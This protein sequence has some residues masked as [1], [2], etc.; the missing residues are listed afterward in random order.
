MNQL[1]PAGRD[2]RLGLVVPHAGVRG[3]F[4]IVLRV[5]V[6]GSDVGGRHCSRGL[7]QLLLANV[8]GLAGF[9]V[10]LVSLGKSRC[11]GSKD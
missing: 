2:R 7:G 11:S 8:A 4:R 10:R 6:A 5:G 1:S 9:G 3:V